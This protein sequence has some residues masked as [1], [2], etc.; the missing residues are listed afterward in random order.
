M[1]I[2]AGC[3]HQSQTFRGHVAGSFA[4]ESFDRVE[5]DLDLSLARDQRV[6]EESARVGAA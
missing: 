3:L 1:T 6:A 2:S 4:G 5:D